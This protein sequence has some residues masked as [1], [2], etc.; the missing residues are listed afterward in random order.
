MIPLWLSCGLNRWQFKLI[1][2][3]CS[4]DRKE[5]IGRPALQ[6]CSPEAHRQGQIC[7]GTSD[8]A[9]LVVARSRA[10]RCWHGEW[11]PL[12]FVESHRS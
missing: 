9:L 5:L 3:Q 12:G 2:G 4:R 7:E 11:L 8:P 1:S 6:L 10:L